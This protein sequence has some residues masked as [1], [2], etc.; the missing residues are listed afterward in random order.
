MPSVASLRDV[1]TQQQSDLESKRKL[2]DDLMRSSAEHEARG[3]DVKAKLDRES[4]ERYLRD[5]DG[6]A[7][8]IAGYE[9][10]IRRRE[11]KAAEI[12]QRIAELKSRFDREFKELESEKESVLAGFAQS[13]D[14]FEA[15]KRAVKD[16]N[17]NNKQQQLEKDFH[18]DLDKLERER[19]LV[20][21]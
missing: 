4:A 5:A 20:L 17:L 8:T 7:S 13:N 3:D 12:E 1:I 16:R 14:N 19:Q 11:Q 18:R 2:A 9:S 15:A 21:G 6:I 10:D